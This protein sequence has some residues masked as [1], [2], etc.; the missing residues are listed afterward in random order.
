MENAYTVYMNSPNKYIYEKWLWEDYFNWRKEQKRLSHNES[1]AKYRKSLREETEENKMLKRVIKKAMTEW[2][3]N[4][5]R[6]IS[7]TLRNRAIDKYF[8]SK[9]EQ[10]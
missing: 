8:E 2:N 4:K 5:L 7:N 3:I 9:E 6:D 1:M 10:N